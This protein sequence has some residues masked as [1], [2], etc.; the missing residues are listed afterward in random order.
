MYR[1]RQFELGLMRALA[2]VFAG[3]QTSFFGQRKVAHPECVNSNRCDRALIEVYGQTPWRPPRR[4]EGLGL[5][6][7]RLC[8]RE[9]FQNTYKNEPANSWKQSTGL[10]RCRLSTMRS[11]WKVLIRSCKAEELSLSSYR[12]GVQTGR[13][14]AFVTLI[15]VTVHERSG[16]QGAPDSSAGWRGSSSGRPCSRR[17]TSI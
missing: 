8:L 6:I 12:V 14:R 1:A 5:K 13:D 3:P 17:H 15:S 11:F 7:F 2:C 9:A 10:R 4:F 16:G